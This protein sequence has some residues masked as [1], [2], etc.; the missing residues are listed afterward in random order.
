MDNVSR[1]KDLNSTQSLNQKHKLALVWVGICLF[2]SFLVNL[3]IYALNLLDVNLGLP[4]Q[5]LAIFDGIDTNIKCFLFVW[6]DY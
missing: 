2:P 6:I 4:I 1:T 3:N 5:C